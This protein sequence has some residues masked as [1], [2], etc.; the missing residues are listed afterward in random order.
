[1]SNLNDLYKEF[2]ARTIDCGLALPAELE[3]IAQQICSL[4]N[5]SAETSTCSAKPVPEIF[6]GIH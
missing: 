1:M 3:E 2:F 5:S 6:A 4:Q